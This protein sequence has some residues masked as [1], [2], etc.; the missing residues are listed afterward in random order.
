MLAMW[1]RECPDRVAADLRRFFGVRLSDMYA[2]VEDVLEVAHMVTHMPRGGAISEWLGGWGAVTAE[3][4]ALRRIEY[5]LIAVN[6]KKKPK[7]PKP[8]EGVREQ[9]SKAKHAERMAE[10]YRRHRGK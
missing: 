10:K 9:V 2:G 4:E 5:V 1:L 8:P 7:P 6:S 3:D